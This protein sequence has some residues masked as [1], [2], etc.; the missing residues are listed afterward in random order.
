MPSIRDVAMRA[1]VSPMTVSRVVNNGD[2][3]RPE[4][5][6]RVELAIADLAYIPNS[7]GHSLRTKRTQTLAL[8]QGDIM[9]PFATMVARGV[10][11]AANRRGYHVI[12]GN[13]D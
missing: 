4:T 13:T 8:V 10:E 7:L 5:R 1:G 12:F 3:V 9:N 6:Q 2:H 11:D